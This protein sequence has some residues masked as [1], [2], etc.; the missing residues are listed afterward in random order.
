MTRPTKIYHGTSMS[1][2][3]F[4]SAD[5]NVWGFHGV[6]A[7][8]SRVVAECFA[9]GVFHADEDIEF[10]DDLDYRIFIGEVDLTDALDLTDYDVQDALKAEYGDLI[11]DGMVQTVED[12]DAQIVILPDLNRTGEREILIRW[13]NPFTTV[14][15]LDTWGWPV[16]DTLL[17]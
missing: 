1:Y 16:S 12:S 8:E 2:E 4:P 3:G 10:G 14:E 7:S 11:I 6:T 5:T 17:S 13:G 9:F 15:K